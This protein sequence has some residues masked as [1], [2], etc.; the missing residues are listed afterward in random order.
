M[1]SLLF[2]WPDGVFY[3]WLYGDAWV[4]ANLSGVSEA[5]VILLHG[6]ADGAMGVN[7]AWSPRAGPTVTVQRGWGVPC[8]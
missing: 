6:I 2:L 8:V 4:V 1:L 3:H 7:S 5:G